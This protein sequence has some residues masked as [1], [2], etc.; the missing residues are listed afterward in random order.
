MTLDEA[1]KTATAK[2]FD[3]RETS[4]GVHI[5]HDMTTVYVRD[6]KEGELKNARL[7]CVAQFWGENTRGDGSRFAQVQLRFDG[8]TSSWVSRDL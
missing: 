8:S 4:F 5:D 6:T 1:V 2:A 7:Y 3:N